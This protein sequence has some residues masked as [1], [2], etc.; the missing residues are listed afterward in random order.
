MDDK[1]TCIPNDNKQ[2]NPFYRFKKLKHF[3]SVHI[4]QVLKV[5]NPKKSLETSI[6]YSLMSPSSLPPWRRKEI[7]R[8][9]LKKESTTFY[10]LCCCNNWG[11]CNLIAGHWSVN[12]TGTQSFIKTFSH[13]SRWLNNLGH[14][15]YILIASH[16]LILPSLGTGCTSIY[17][18]ISYPLKSQ[19]TFHYK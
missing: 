11:F 15:Y 13:S 2:D 9:K 1:L 8:V 18:T 3:W 7:D 14:F 12:Y 4:N 17:L 10:I 6:I 16:K 19:Q 5:F